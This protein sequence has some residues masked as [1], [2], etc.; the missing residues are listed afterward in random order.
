MRL[1]NVTKN[2]VDWLRSFFKL[3]VKALEISE[4]KKVSFFQVYNLK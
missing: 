3:K 1:E 2:H 4:G